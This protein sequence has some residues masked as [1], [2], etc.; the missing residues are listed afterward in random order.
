MIT[1]DTI[2]EIGRQILS[3]LDPIAIYAFGSVAAGRARPESDIDLAILSRRKLSENE[4]ADAKLALEEEYSRDVDLIDMAAA[5]TVLRKEIFCGG[6]L[7]YESGRTQREE[8]EMY[9]L[10]DYARLN[11]ERAPVLAALGHPLSN[12]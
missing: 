12:A 9:I 2:A 6:R 8:F 5:S 10:S 11:E 3:G 4:L 1:I 7:L